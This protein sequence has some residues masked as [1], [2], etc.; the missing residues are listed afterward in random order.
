MYKKGIKR[1]FSLF[2]SIA[3]VLSLFAGISLNVN[4]EEDYYTIKFDANGGS[5]TQDDLKISKDANSVTIPN[6]EFKRDGY[7]FMGW[8][9]DRIPMDNYLISPQEITPSTYSI[10][11]SFLFNSGDTVTFVA[12]WEDNSKEYTI[13]FD[14]NGGSGS[15]A[16]ITGVTYSKLSTTVVPQCNFTKYV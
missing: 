9:C 11:K 12:Q 2:L 1:V 15:Q 5:G 7:A 13:N 4:A 14:A 3:L 16:S 10:L 8:K 6:C